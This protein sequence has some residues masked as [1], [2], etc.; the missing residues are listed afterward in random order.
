MVA[1]TVGA[2]LYLGHEVNEKRL[3]AQELTQAAKQEF[4][5]KGFNQ[6]TVQNR[7]QV[8]VIYFTETEA[9]ELAKLLQNEKS[10][11]QLF[12]KKAIYNIN[13]PYYR[14]LNIAV[15]SALRDTLKTGFGYEK[16]TQKAVQVYQIFKTAIVRE[17]G[18]NLVESVKVAKQQ[19]L[20]C[21]SLNIDK[22]SNTI[23]NLKRSRE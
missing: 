20:N 12:L 10:L 11:G 7:A 4:Y 3:K 19:R 1:G 16:D 8:Q 14:T 9:K 21:L 13:D 22:L 5:H 18:G 17:E 15:D 6:L 23:Q 2:G